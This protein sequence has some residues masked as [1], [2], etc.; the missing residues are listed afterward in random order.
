[1]KSVKLLFVWAGLVLTFNTT[2]Q[3]ISAVSPSVTNVNGGGWTSGFYFAG[4]NHLV[5]LM[6]WSGT[7]QWG[8]SDFIA[9]EAFPH[10]VPNVVV[11]CESNGRSVSQ[12]MTTW[13]TTWDTGLP[14]MI[15]GLPVRVQCSYSAGSLTNN[16]AN[17]YERY[18]VGI[19]GGAGN[20]WPGGV[21]EQ[22]TIPARRECYGS[23]GDLPLGNILA[24]DSKRVEWPYSTNGKISISGRSIVM[25]DGTLML[26]D[27][28]ISGVQV[29]PVDGSII[30][31]DFATSSWVVSSGRSS[32]PLSLTVAPNQPLGTY[33]STLTATLS[34][35]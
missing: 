20:L 21:A 16:S 26:G 14:I 17:R 27:G 13:R 10:V 23:I 18:F 25:F 12:R 2:A 34:C 22:I 6:L 29:R 8:S 3:Q 15:N 31:T 4:T 9:E 33:S 7:P 28:F 35:E 11:T 1:M 24:G 19:V 5:Q 30:Q 32:I